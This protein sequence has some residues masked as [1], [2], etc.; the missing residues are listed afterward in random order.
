MLVKNIT[1]N[2][3]TIRQIPLK[4]LGDNIPKILEVRGEVIIS[5]NNF[6][7]LNE[8]REKTMNHYLLILVM[9]QLGQL[10]N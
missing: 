10:G 5:N 6:T 8:N 3:R 1:Q 9:R 7:E 4:L 2:L